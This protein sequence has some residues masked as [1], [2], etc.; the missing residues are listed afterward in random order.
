MMKKFYASLPVLS[1]LL[2]AFLL[3]GCLRA[4]QPATPAVTAPPSETALSL[5]DSP[6]APPTVSPAPSSTP[7]AE[8]QPSPAPDA[9]RALVVVQYASGDTV[10]REITFTAPISG[11]LAL[12]KTGLEIAAQD[13]QF[14]KAVC[15][16]EATG[17][18]ADN[19]FCDAN[20]YWGYEYWDGSAWQGYQV[21]AGDTQ[22]KDGAVEGWRWGESGKGFLPPAQAVL[23]AGQALDWLEA[24]QAITNG[25]F[26]SP[27]GSVEAALALGAN[28]YQA[29]Q[30]QPS[31]G[32][33][34]LLDYLTKNTAEFANKNVDSS[35]KLALAL[36]GAGG[37]WPSGAKLPQDYYN[38]G[39]GSYAD[40]AG[41]GA[42]GMLGVAALDELIPAEAIT[43]LTGLQ[44]KDGG[45]EWSPGFG[46]DTNSTALAIQALVAAGEPL[47]STVIANGLSFIK[48]AQGKD[49]GFT[50]SP[51]QNSG[52]DADSTAYVVQAIVSAGQDP[53]TTTWKVEGNTPISYLL[54]LQLPDGSFE[55]QKGAGSNALATQQAV[56]A[57]LE[58]SYPLKRSQLKSCQ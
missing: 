37:C 24:R 30:W 2:L 23:A 17:C 7:P 10:A 15:S 47:T 26:G 36:A 27:G 29:A 28:D 35:G 22:L 31:Q 34:T 54:S 9:G 38:S 11:F 8:A 19:C 49:G 50:Y 53:V 42:L 32:T 5:P 56:A 57:L 44:Q 52:S 25:G 33:P 14:G 43:A 45:W 13:T 6:T 58:R 20:H 12:Q 3:V 1:G 51:A 16:I 55:W 46:S 39:T 48:T 4:T 18:P 41:G 40:G 21:G